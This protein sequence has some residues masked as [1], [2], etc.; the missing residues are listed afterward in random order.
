MKKFV[1]VLAFALACVSGDPALSLPLSS[2]ETTPPHGVGAG[3]WIAGTVMLS[4]FSLIV[5]S[6]V[7]GQKTGK[8]LTS[9]QAWTYATLPFGCL[10][11]PSH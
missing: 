7:V 1:F 10:Y 9:Q 2:G 5:C 8:Q 11:L 6:K 3:P 4:A